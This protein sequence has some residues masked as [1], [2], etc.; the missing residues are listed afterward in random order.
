[1]CGG[2]GL[3]IARDMA[4]KVILVASNDLHLYMWLTMFAQ[5][6]SISEN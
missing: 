6:S 5:L 2:F 1:V 4:Q 3:P